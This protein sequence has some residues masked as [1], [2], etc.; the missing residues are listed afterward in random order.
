MVK[1]QSPQST[2]LSRRPSVLVMSVVGAIVG[3]GVLLVILAQSLEITIETAAGDRPSS[4]DIESSASGET[5]SGSAHPVPDPITPDDFEPALELPESDTASLPP[6]VAIPNTS[7]SETEAA[8][9]VSPGNLR[10]SNQTIH[11]VRVA[12]LSQHSVGG[13]ESDA[14]TESTATNPAASSYREPIHWDFVPGE[15]SAR[16]LVLG[17]PDAE[18]AIQRGD[19]ITAFAQDGSQRYW[20]PYVV[21]DTDFPRWNRETSEWVLILRVNDNL[22]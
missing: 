9:P 3:I 14:S 20:G 17:L 11:P 21:G 10:V 5:A 18:L 1:E 22:E 2:S 19:V 13:Q 4:P 8:A 7:V 6:S 15:G 16:G 12:I